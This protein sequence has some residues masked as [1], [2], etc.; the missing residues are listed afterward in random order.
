MTEDER[1]QYI[2]ELVS[3]YAANGEEVTAL[4]ARIRHQADVLNGL[5]LA[6]HAYL[7]TK[8]PEGVL[9][10][11]LYT[12]AN[13]GQIAADAKELEAAVERRVHLEKELTRANLGN[14]IKSF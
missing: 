13:P 11:H 6:A 4:R 1:K 7:N 9:N 12:H 14:L 5:V 10:H 2:G 3:Q 8:D